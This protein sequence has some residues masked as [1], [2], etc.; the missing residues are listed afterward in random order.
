LQAMGI[1]PVIP[2]RKTEHVK[3]RPGAIV[4]SRG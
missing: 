2:M 4:K 1:E 3:D